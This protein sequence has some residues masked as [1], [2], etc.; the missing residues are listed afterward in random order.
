M[1]PPVMEIYDRHDPDFQ[2]NLNWQQKRKRAN[3]YLLKLAKQP[4]DIFPFFFIWNDFVAEQLS[5]QYRGIKWHRHPDEPIYH[6]EDPKCRETIEKI[7]QLSIPICYEEEFDNTLKFIQE[8]AV[9]IPVI[10]PHCGR[11]NGGYEA[12]CQAGIWEMSNIYTDTSC[13]T[14]P[15]IIM[16]YIGRYGSERIMFG[17][18]FPFHDPK[19]QLEKIEQLP[20]S[21]EEKAAILSLN[22]QKL[23][24]RNSNQD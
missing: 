12:L 10:I 18:D 9:D 16:D 13:E 14:S 1:F 17:S 23:L 21:E 5:E 2:D 15:E 20:L 19:E 6:Y 22:V 8:L 11:L 24:I 4:I 7:R 3:E